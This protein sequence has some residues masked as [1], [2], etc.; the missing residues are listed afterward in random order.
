VAAR[1]DAPAVAWFASRTEYERALAAGFPAR[2]QQDREIASRES[3]PAY[4]VYCHAEREFT[5]SVGLRF[6]QDVD[7]RSGLVCRTCGLNNR[8]RLLYHAVERQAGGQS[9]LQGLR[10]YL[11]ERV[12]LFHDRLAERA[13]RLVGSEYLSADLSPGQMRP[14]APSG[15]MGLVAGLASRLGVPVLQVRHEDLTALSFPPAS[16]DLVVHGD[17][18]EHIPAPRRALAEIHRVLAPG[19][20]TVF[21]APFLAGHDAHEVRAVVDPGGTVRHLLPPEIHGNPIHAGGSLVFQTLGW[22]VL[23]DLRTAGFR[24]AAVGVIADPAYAFTSNNSSYP[25]YMEAVV[26]RGEKA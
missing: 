24:S 10:L 13:P 26:F 11:A 9:G 17:V 12:S 19:G 7:L 6:G 1:P 16:F 18:L 23:D 2:R 5:V 4:C 3:W 14:F 15:P 22:E 20:A 21:T 25:N 8:Q